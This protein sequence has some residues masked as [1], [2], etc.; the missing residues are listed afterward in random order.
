M[1][2]RKKLEEQFEYEIVDEF[3]DHFGMMCDILEPTVLGVKNAAFYDD[4]VNQI[5]RTMH[6]IK[7][8]TGYLKLNPIQKLAQ[9]TE[10]FLTTMR[11]Y[12]GPASEETLNWLLAINDQFSAWNK[13]LTEDK[14]KLTKI[15]YKLLKL[16]DLEC[17]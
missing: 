9:F 13:D 3:I 4:S 10:D 16:P 11:D 1:G 6:N 7:S 5:F 15:E 12:K 14:E 17:S 2:V 8:A